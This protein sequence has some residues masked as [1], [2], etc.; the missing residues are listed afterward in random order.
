MRCKTAKSQEAINI[1]DT[2]AQPQ[3]FMQDGVISG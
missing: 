3:V 2:D 1:D